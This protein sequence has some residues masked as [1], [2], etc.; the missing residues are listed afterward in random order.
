MSNPH[1]LIARYG[2]ATNALALWLGAIVLLLMRVWVAIAFWRAGLVKIDDPEG[3]RFLFTTMYHVPLL[4][5]AVAAWLG[6]WIEL[7]TPWLLGLG[8]V[9]RFTALFLFVYN[10]IAVISFPNLWPHGFW[11]GLFN[12]ASFAD[13]KTWGLMLLAVVAWGS[14]RLSV[15]ALCIRGYRF[16]RS[17]SEHQA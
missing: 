2:S 13:H 15:D 10:L 12:T 3:T 6:T 8:I 11:T 14:G 1:H 5:A 4:S 17:K 9:G 7:V 16:W